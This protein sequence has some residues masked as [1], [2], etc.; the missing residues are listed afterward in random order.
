MQA[1]YR[2]LEELLEDTRAAKESREVP[3]VTVLQVKRIYRKLA[4]LIHPDI[5]PASREDPLLQDLWNRITIAYQRNDVKELQELEVLTVNALNS[6]DIN[7]EFDIPDLAEK[8]RSLQ[9]EIAMIT[10]TAPY[11]YRDILEDP[12]KS[13]QKEE[14]LKRQF[15]EY[16][17]Y[18]QELQL[19]LD[20]M[21]VQ[22]G[23]KITWRMKL[24]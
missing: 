6:M 9:D 18:E 8:I 17:N 7:I 2:Q 11:I 16:E 24:H 15:E 5:N 20:E 10:G 12:D 21:T 22:K 1:Y 23:R 13:R 3:A 19:V 14:E 4:K